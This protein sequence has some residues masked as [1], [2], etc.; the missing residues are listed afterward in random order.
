MTDDTDPTTLTGSPD[1]DGG[2]ERVS[3]GDITI[4]LPDPSGRFECGHCGKTWPYDSLA[5]K[6]GRRRDAERHQRTHSGHT[7]ITHY[8]DP[9][10]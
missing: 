7:T 4:E 5:G 2:D 10:D 9:D 8:T 3:V 6:V 1:E